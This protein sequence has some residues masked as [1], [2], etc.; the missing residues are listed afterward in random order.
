MEYMTVIFRSV[1]V[2]VPGR[3]I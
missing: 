1:S 2:F 3:R